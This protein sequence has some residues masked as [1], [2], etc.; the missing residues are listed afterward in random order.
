MRTKEPKLIGYVNADYAR[1]KNSSCSTTGWVFLM[2]RGS[3]AWSA[4]K[5]PTVSL[6]STKGEY[7]AA[8]SAA[9]K[10]IWARQ[11]LSELRFLSDG[12]TVLFTD[13]RSSMALA[14]NPANHQSTKHIH[15]KYQFIHEVIELQEVELQY[16]PTKEQV[17]DTLTKPLGC[18]KLP[19]FVSGMGMDQC[20]NFSLNFHSFFPSPFLLPCKPVWAC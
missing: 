16:T 12:P 6:S 15:V 18:V 19:G 2:S 14:R 4:H 13:N 3:V 1:D 5:Q 20:F 17:A 11:F 10:I 7:V 8:A 9:H